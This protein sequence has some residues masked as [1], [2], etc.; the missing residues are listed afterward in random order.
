MANLDIIRGRQVVVPLTNKSGGQL[1]EGDVVIVDEANTAAVT[2]TNVEGDT[3]VV[4]I[5]AETV[6]A[7][8]Q[9]R[10][11]IAGYAATLKV[12]GATAIGD[13]LVTSTTPKSATPKVAIEAGVFGIAISSSAGAGTVAAILWV[14]QGGP[15]GE[16]G[17]PG[18]PGAPGGVSIQYK[19]GG[20]WPE[21]GDGYLKL[22]NADP[23]LV[24]EIG[25]DWLNRPLVDVEDLVKEF[26]VVGNRLIIHS[27]IT[28]EEFW[29]YEVSGA[30][31]HGASCTRVP[32]TYIDH[33]GGY[34]EDEYVFVSVGYKGDQGEQ[35][36]QGEP[37]P[38]G[39]EGPPGSPVSSVL[40]VIDGG[41][42]VIATGIKGD[43][44]VDFACTIQQWTLVADQ[45]GSIVIDIWK[46]VYASFPPDNADS[47]CGGNEPALVAAD[48]NQDAVLAGWTT[49]IAAGDIL[50]FNVDSVAT[51]QRVTLALKVQRV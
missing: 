51:V 15:Q 48:K 47:I 9:G 1:V 34:A 13:F 21:T 26:C 42:A 3:R 8:A 35:G 31:V 22:N 27:E 10:F 6:V 36:E 33:S 28:P 20:A 23:T 50:R 18:D 11:L 44:V 29:V 17:D 45:V 5:A 30:A 4:G 25:L 2:T 37:G 19:Q 32:V 7:E 41:G 39:P 49:A 46:D 24:T 43:L 12:D 16:A 40:F 14:G 38:E